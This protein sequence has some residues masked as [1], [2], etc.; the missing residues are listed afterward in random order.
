MQPKMIIVAGPPGSG[1]S[2]AFPVNSFEFD[3]FNAD[4][5]AAEIN[6]GSYQG[7][8]PAIRTIVNQEYEQFVAEHIVAKKG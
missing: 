4:D 6:N 2:T 7:I 5:R 3:Y 1:K 8:P